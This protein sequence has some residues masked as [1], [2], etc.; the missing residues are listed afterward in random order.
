[1]RIYFSTLLLFI[2]HFNNFG[3]SLTML[4]NSKMQLKIELNESLFTTHP[5]CFGSSVNLSATRAMK[6]D[7]PAPES[8]RI[9]SGSVS[10]VDAI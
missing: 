9:T 3:C 8:P 2:A 7:L 1:M 6:A 5:S 10:D 4:Y